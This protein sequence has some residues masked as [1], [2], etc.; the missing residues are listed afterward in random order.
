MEG[1]SWIAKKGA[2]EASKFGSKLYN[3][4][5]EYD[6]RAAACITDPQINEV[7]GVKFK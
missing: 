7:D 1:A 6:R 2:V 3:L 5:T 4:S